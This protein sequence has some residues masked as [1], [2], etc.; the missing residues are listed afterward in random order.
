MV[1]LVSLLFGA[2]LGW[3]YSVLAR[4]DTNER[5][6]IDILVGALGAVAMALALGNNSVF[7]SVLAAFLGAFVALAVLY[8]AR[9]KLRWRN[10]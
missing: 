4:S 9:G 5:I 8:V 3:A 1:I 7:D 2:L 6:I 10:R